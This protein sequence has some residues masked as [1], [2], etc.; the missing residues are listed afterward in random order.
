MLHLW[1]P[2]FEWLLHI[3]YRI[4]VKPLPKWQ[5]HGPVLKN[6]VIQRKITLQE[7]FWEKM[8]LRVDFPSKGGSGN[9]NS[10]PVARVAFSNPEL[11]AQILEVDVDLVKRVITILIALSCQLPLDTEFFSAFCDGTAILYVAKYK[12]FPMPQ[13]VHK[14]LIHFRDPILAND[15]LLE[16]WLRMQ[17][18]ATSSIDIFGN[19]MPEKLA[20]RKI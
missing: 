14:I 17:R 5:M 3:S 16:F 13:S 20:A 9:S 8:N 10:G 2:C 1:I 19:F 6:E 7:K 18:S 4:N 11:L 12:W 15:L